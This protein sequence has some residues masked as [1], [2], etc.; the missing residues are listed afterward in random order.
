[1]T[2]AVLLYIDGAWRPGTSGRELANVDP[3]TGA[4]IGMLAVA[5][6]SDVAQAADAAGRAFPAWSEKSALERSDLL[7]AAAALVRE[8]LE[9]IA[10]AMTVE[11]GK[12]LA[13]SRLEA[14]LA[15]EI[16]E[17]FAE[18][19]R[20]AYGR[21]VPSRGPE[22]TQT[23]VQVPVGPVAAFAPWNFPLTQVARKVGAA[24]AAGC[25]IVVKPPEEAPNCAAALFACFVDAGIPH[26]VAN[27]VFGVP[28][29][30]S[31]TL[32]PHGAIRKISFTG[33]V[34]VGKHL[35]AMAGRHMKRATMELG[36]HA[37]VIVCADADIELAAERLCAAKF[38]N[39]G[40]VCI[41]PTRFLVHRAVF[42]QFHD[43]FLE[44][45]ARI[46]VGNGLT[47]GMTMGPL[48]NERRLAA[49]EAFVEDARAKGATVL[50]GG[51]R[52]GGKGLF[53]A[54]TVLT[55]VTLEMDVLRDEPFGPVALLQPFSTLDEA[56]TEAN[57]LPFG[58]AA[59]A[60]TDSAATIAR[61]S[62]SVEVGMLGVN[63]TA[64]AYAETPFGGVRDS[65]YGSDGGAEGLHGYLQPK[66][67]TVS[68]R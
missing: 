60:F 4:T 22:V 53:Y 12:P 20:R 63:H 45:V 52:I 54:P 28:S 66:L 47:D 25:T 15:A 21:V 24:L 62:A 30:V 39:A 17:W 65:G 37:P 18:E 13:E 34:P 7:R 33:S 56:I 67:V 42:K 9:E 64:I 8:R 23:V 16:I 3:A 41:S 46:R 6:P 40:Q 2:D 43:A 36:G 38:S 49:V 44:R 59:Y 27:L 55:R 32:I 1:V 58:L 5:D 19:G 10:R 51:H 57:R 26:G 68:T 31:E 61:L 50:A 35:A 11:Q 48:N 14:I 29:E